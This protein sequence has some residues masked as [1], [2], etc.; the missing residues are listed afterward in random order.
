MLSIGSLKAGSEGYYSHMAGQ[1]EYYV[2]PGEEK[3]GVWIGGA[4]EKFSEKYGLSETVT[5]DEFRALFRGY[6][7]DGK[8]EELVQN[9]GKMTR[10]R[11]GEG[12]VINPKEPIRQP[13]WDLTFSAPKSVSILHALTTDQGLKDALERSHLEAIKTTFK[14]IEAE[15]FTRI[16]KGGKERVGAELSV[17][18]FQHETARP[19]K[20]EMPDPQL[21]SHAVV[22]NVC[23]NGIDDKTRSIWSKRF[24]EQEHRYGA[25]YRAE[26]SKHIEALGFTTY[27]VGD[28]FEVKGVPE[29]LMKALSKRSAEIKGEAVDESAK[30]REKATLKPRQVKGDYT[31]EQLLERWT[32]TARTHG[33]KPEKINE[34]RQPY[35]EERSLT[36]ESRKA[37]REALETVIAKTPRFT[38][39][40]LEKA[41]HVQAQDKGI[42]AAAV[43]GAVKAYL[44]TEA[45]QVGATQKGEKVF[46]TQAQA[47]KDKKEYQEATRQEEK[48]ARHKEVSKA[49]YDEI[50][51]AHQGSKFIALTADR[52]GA[53]RLQKRIGMQAASVRILLNEMEGRRFR[54]T[55]SV[56][57]MIKG[58][59]SKQTVEVDR[60]K[61]E[62][63]KLARRINAEAKYALAMISAKTRKKLTGDLH[64]PSFEA[65]HKFLWATG[66]ITK[67]QMR[68]LDAE[69]RHKRLE[70][71]KGTVVIIDRSIRNHRLNGKLREEIEKRGGTMVF[72]GDP[73]REGVHEKLPQTKE[74]PQQKHAITEQRVTPDTKQQETHGHRIRLRHELK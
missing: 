20:K 19:T 57:R 64:K 73:I 3:E 40:D 60:K 27:R 39:S 25:I 28:F 36:N 31:K 62:R 34:L 21:H 70:V 55:R 44:S 72:A 42:G 48:V 59:F 35:R 58:D 6:S 2:R 61:E 10:T 13:G 68:H 53:D 51:A 4:A 11:D 17:A 24:Y 45:A 12:K 63:K 65:A 46:T 7:P 23:T 8:K 37:V 52:E 66:Q 15:T 69:L 54:N 32:E 33:L 14:T 16:G 49:S 67:N 43:I 9:A 71:K 47:E 22:I 30:A 5:R 26:L 50:R 1:D 41:A 74:L 29:P 56:K 38:E 18:V